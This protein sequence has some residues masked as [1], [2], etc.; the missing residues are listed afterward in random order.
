MMPIKDSSLSVLDPQKV[1]KGIFGTQGLWICDTAE[2]T[3][4]I[5]HGPSTATSTPEQF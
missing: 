5:N 4:F 2:L 1:P 3:S